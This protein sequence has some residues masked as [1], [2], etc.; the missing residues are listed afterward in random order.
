MKT[1]GI[2][3]IDCHGDMLAVGGRYSLKEGGSLTGANDGSKRYPW[4]DLPRCQSCHTGDAV[5]HLTGDDLIV[6]EKGIRLQQAYRKGDRSAS[7]I[8]AENQ[9]FAENA[10]TLFRNSKG[11]GGIAC[12]GCHGSTHATWPNPNAKANDNLTAEQL[13]GHS[14]TIIECSACHASGSLLLTVEGPH[15]LHNVSDERWTDGRHGH[16]Y[17]RDEALCQACHGV[18]LEGTPLAKMSK[19]RTV[20][21]GSRKVTLQQ[22]EN[23]SC[24]LCHKKP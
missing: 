18:N 9:R 20:S 24:N 3:C 6:H 8:L 1:G 13:Q 23:V 22:G 2:T 15:G 17:E 5:K 12:E 21:I 10:K 14:G 11:H 16:Y 4:Q 19:T 7:P